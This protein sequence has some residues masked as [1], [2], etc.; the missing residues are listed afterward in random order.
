MIAPLPSKQP[1]TS[2]N[3]SM[4]SRSH[5]HADR[6]SFKSEDG[7][8]IF[9]CLESRKFK[10]AIHRINNDQSIARRAQEEGN[11]ALHEACRC[12]APVEL[13][14]ALIEANEAAL[15]VAGKMGYLPLHFACG[16][17]TS[18]MV[19]SMLVVAY[20]PA[21]RAMEEKNGGLPLHLAVRSSSDSA[22]ITAV[23]AAYPKASISRDR[24]GQTPMDHAERL[25]SPSRDII[26]VLR[27]APTLVALN[28]AVLESMAHKCE[29]KIQEKVKFYEQRTRSSNEQYEVNIAQS[30]DQVLA[31]QKKLKAEKERIK[32]LEGEVRSLKQKLKES[33]TVPMSNKK[34]PDQLHSKGD[35]KK[36]VLIH[37]SRPPFK[38]SRFEKRVREEPGTSDRQLAGEKSTLSLICSSGP[39][40]G[41]F[42][43]TDPAPQHL[44]GAGKEDRDP[45]ATN[46]RIEN[47]SMAKHIDPDSHPRTHMRDWFSAIIL[48]GSDDNMSTLYHGS[49]RL[50]EM[51]S[52]PMT[53]VAAVMKDSSIQLKYPRYP[54]KRSRPIGGCIQTQVK[55]SLLNRSKNTKVPSTMLA[56]ERQ[57]GQMSKIK[58]KYLSLKNETSNFLDSTTYNEAFWSPREADLPATP[59][60]NVTTSAYSQRLLD[61]DSAEAAT[62]LSN[63]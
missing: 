46:A 3:I 15:A 50:S 9:R 39:S 23:L 36:E 55:P 30:N 6:S 8:D 59:A 52:Q 21:A 20:P 41:T 42:R 48:E 28:K 29:A 11:L 34:L 58:P 53:T 1:H 7:F 10:E 19:I 31:L 16:S 12:G 38:E 63:P 18:P 5:K 45:P 49:G 25:S 60:K 37:A 17:N 24:S 56:L 26:K 44:R 33:K 27:Q 57:D 47:D 13:I 61:E 2:S 22:V 62:V 32:N 14:A 54:V 51:S 4:R 43:G 40:N 35:F